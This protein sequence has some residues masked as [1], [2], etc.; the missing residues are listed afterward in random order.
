MSED[1]RDEME[2]MAVTD[3]NDLSDEELEA[4]SGGFIYHDPGNAAAHRKE[5]FYVLNDE[6]DIL[7]KLGSADAAHHWAGNLRE[8]TRFLTTSEFEKLRRRR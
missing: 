3:I 5:A 7:M 1:L 8:S 4:I 6:G 2:E